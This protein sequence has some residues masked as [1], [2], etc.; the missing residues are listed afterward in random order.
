MIP[1][2][3]RGLEA[4]LAQTERLRAGLPVPYPKGPPP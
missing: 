4:L 2:I 3:R 1:A